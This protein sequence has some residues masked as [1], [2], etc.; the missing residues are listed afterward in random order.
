MRNIQ[1][2]APSSESSNQF[3]V[4]KIDKAAAMLLVGGLAI[5]ALVAVLLSRE[6]PLRNTVQ[7]NNPVSDSSAASLSSAPTQSSSSES[8][9]LPAETVPTTPMEQTPPVEPPPADQ[10]SDLTVSPPPPPGPQIISSVSVTAYPQPDPTNTPQ[11]D[12]PAPEGPS[13]DLPANS[14]SPSSPDPAPKAPSSS[15]DPTTPAMVNG[16]GATFPY[17]LYSKWFDEFHKLHPRVQFNYQAV[18]SGAGIKQLQEKVV[19]F[20]ATDVPMND[21]QLA[22]VD[23]SVLHVPSVIGGVVPV[24]NLPGV[25]EL[26]FTPEI[27]AAIYSGRVVSWNAPVIAAV[28]PSKDLPD[29]PII[30]IRRSD[31]CATTFI[32]TDYLSKVS[33]EW[34]QTVGW[35]ASVNWPVGIAAKGDEGVT[36]LLRQTPG[37]I[38]YVDFLY[39]LQNRIPFASVRNPAGKFIKANLASLTAAGLVANNSNDFRV[40]I[41]N[42]P[43]PDAYPISSFTWILAPLRSRNSSE[44]QDLREFLRWMLAKNSQATASS[45][46]YAPLPEQLAA[47]IDNEV[48]RIH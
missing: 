28:N 17:P 38:A 3:L 31:G 10:A 45:L 15:Y 22:R 8:Q 1:P 33:P 7:S 35:G 39:A 13:S 36:S 5:V 42:A 12:T 18:G 19:D 34:K 25:A 44:A 40:T 21:Q 20:G 29:L 46:G 4:V 32:F 48:S 11:T 14:S 43:A 24:Y 23:M 9:Q 26:R 16:A 37:A 27:L 30:V 41:T 47:R 2:S 6:T